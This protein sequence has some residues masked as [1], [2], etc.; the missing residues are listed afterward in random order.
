[1]PTNINF[2]GRV[3]ARPGVYSRI[4]NDLVTNTPAPTGNLAVIGDFDMLPSR[5]PVTFASRVD[6]YNYTRNLDR[7][8]SRIADLAFSPLGAD[9]ASIS[10]LTL[11]NYGTNSFAEI[12][13]TSHTFTSKLGGL[14][15]NRTALKIVEQADGRFDIKVFHGGLRDPQNLVSRYTN[16][17]LATGESIASIQA[18]MIGSPVTY[19]AVKLE[20]D[21][22]N[23][24]VLGTPVAG[25]A[26]VALATF[27]VAEEQSINDLLD[28]IQS[29]SI[30]DVA[31]YA[32]S[33][34]A[35][36]LPLSRMDSF[37]A[38]SFVASALKFTDN[39]QRLVDVLA[40][41]SYVG[42]ERSSSSVGIEELTVTRMTGG[43][44]N[45]A[46]TDANFLAALDTIKD[47]AV[48]TL[49]VLSTSA[50]A[51]QIALQHC[52]DA[53]DEFGMNRNMWAGS[54]SNTVSNAYASHS[55]VLNSE[56]ASIVFQTAELSD[57]AVLSTSEVALMLAAIQNALPAATPL[58]KRRLRSDIV[59]VSPA[60]TA[61]SDIEDT[62]NKGIVAITLFR[63][64]GLS[65]ERA[66]TTWMLDDNPIK[67]EVSSMA[68]VNQS[69][70][71]LRTAVL[72]KIGAR[73]TAN[74][75]NDL[76]AIATKE[77]SQ[78]K[79]DGLIFDFANLAVNLS[80]DRAD[81]TYDVAAAEPLN[82]IT[83]T[84]N[85]VR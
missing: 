58:T 67:S 27:I 51:Q 53:A 4:V 30:S 55:A 34:A 63:P 59:S 65:V 18:T 60:I 69:V 15:G 7:Q 46:L 16:I 49:V 11:I 75:Q 22:T 72:S 14:V 62:L 40:F 43:S 61:P 68:S 45:T 32:V 37:A 28:R 71:Q 6:F 44:D 64:F 23:L 3:T 29:L 66:I 47:T 74:M 21:D 50:T 20:L 57:G 5:S 70:R 39:A 52:K 1:M 76:L 17:G 2:N 84:A 31:S 38:T 10:S 79:A 19:S 24:K 9:S 77:L 48:N 42:A 73:I 81:L 26:D 78:Q 41:D 25:G 83:I 35:R 8:L 33:F 54:S 85:I 56:L 13:S 36:D 82:F 80:G 12:S